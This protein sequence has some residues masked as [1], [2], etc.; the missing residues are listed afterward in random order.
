MTKR[1]KRRIA[2]I[3][4]KHIKRI[5]KRMGRWFYVVG[6]GILGLFVLGCVCAWA[7][8]GPNTR[9]GHNGQPYSLYIYPGQAYSTVVDSLEANNVISSGWSFGLMARLL[10]YP[11]LV[12]PGHYA[13]G[14]NLS[15][16]QL[17]RRLRAGA[18]TPIEVR[19][20]TRR[21]ASFMAGYLA[22]VF[23]ADSAAFDSV[24]NDERLLDSLGVQR[25]TVMALFLPNTYEF[26]WT[27]KPE[28][29][30]SRMHKL[31]SDY[32][33]DERKAKA[34]ARGLTPLK[35]S[36][37]ASIVQAE[38]QRHADERAAIAGLYLNR[39]EKRMKLQA[40]PTVIFALQDW[41][42]RRVLFSHL[43]YDS[44]YNTYKYAGLPPGPINN[45]SLSAIEGVLNPQKHNYLFMSARPD[46]SG[47]HYFSETFSE[48]I[49]KANAYRNRNR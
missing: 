18:Q 5:R 48:H 39:L 15:N 26:Y 23:M 45:P 43:R 44:P 47:Y 16:L 31:W 22:E 35:V 20:P 4:A 13:I 37:L 17:I 2:L 49:R 33:T 32:W 34:E 42:I 40:D 46:G 8:I 27:S 19:I 3:Q 24:L 10:G 41:S 28:A 29:V 11:K 21:T 30:L 9:G 12:K 38:Q 36:I 25:Q 14:A 7:F 1:K 6:I